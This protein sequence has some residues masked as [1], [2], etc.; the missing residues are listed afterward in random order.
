MYFTNKYQKCQ[1]WIVVLLFALGLEVAKSQVT[2][3]N[4][5][6]TRVHRNGCECIHHDC[7]CCGHIEWDT[8]SWNGTLCATAS[9]LDHDYGFSVTLTYNNITIINETISARNPPPICIGEDIIENLKAE[10]CL[11]LYDITINK[12]HFHGCLELEARISKLNIL[13][14][15][16]GCFD[17][18]HKPVPMFH[19]P[20]KSHMNTLAFNVYLFLLYAEARGQLAITPKQ[21]NI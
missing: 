12:S 19:A 5:N 11:R 13:P 16:L 9:Y 17:N 7:A 3:N 18:E 6:V 14:I 2:Q 4:D 1:I 20:L 8:V 21:L 15:H 10:L